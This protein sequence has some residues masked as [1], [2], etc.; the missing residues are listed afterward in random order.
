MEKGTAQSWI[1]NYVKDWPRNFSHK[2]PQS[3]Y[4]KDLRVADEWVRLT[5]DEIVRAQLEQAGG[6]LLE[7]LGIIT[8]EQL[9]DILCQ[10]GGGPSFLEVSAFVV[11]AN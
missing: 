9:T 5:V 8:V 2:R 4:A 11:V 7:I 3:R 10:V 6:Q 1:V